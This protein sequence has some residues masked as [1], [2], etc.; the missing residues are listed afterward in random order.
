[1][2]TIVDELTQL[3]FI[4]EELFSLDLI[5][6]ATC[7]RLNELVGV[8]QCLIESLVGSMIEAVSVK[9]ALA[10]L[11]EIYS[12]TSRLEQQWRDRRRECLEALADSDTQLR[13]MRLFAGHC[14]IEVPLMNR[15]G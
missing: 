3:A 7:E 6:C 10:A 2:K 8:R 13:Q 5:D 11:Q 9:D 12:R 1:M 14:D 4:D 15:F